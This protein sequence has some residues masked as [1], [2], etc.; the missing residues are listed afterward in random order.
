VGGHQESTD[1]AAIERFLTQYPG[2]ARVAEASQSDRLLR[3]PARPRDGHSRLSGH[4]RRAASSSGVRN[5]PAAA[6]GGTAGGRTPSAQ[7]QASGPR[8][9][10]TSTGSA[11]RRK[12]RSE[13]RPRRRPP[14]TR[15]DSRPRRKRPGKRPRRSWPAPGPR[16]KPP[17]C[18]RRASA[19]GRR[20]HAQRPPRPA[21][22]RRRPSHRPVRPGPANRQA[23]GRQLRHRLRRW[24]CRHREARFDG[25]WEGEMTCP[26]AEM[27]SRGCDVRRL[28]R[29][30]DPGAVVG[31]A[32]WRVIDRLATTDRVA[33]TGISTGQ[34]YEQVFVGRFSGTSFSAQAVAPARPC[35]FQLVRQSP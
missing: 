9:R 7:S 29:R 35:S 24:H 32:M 17:G 6:R 28:P 11:P 1:A 23:C 2:S 4:A 26:G 20:R 3:A 19:E 5:C 15:H 14:P 34:P 25:T 33:R 10:R 18:R 27:R 31:Q 12:R 13:P 30:D 21:R 22:T 16:P 8:P